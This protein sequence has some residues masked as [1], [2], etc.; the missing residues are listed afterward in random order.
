MTNQELLQT[1]RKQLGKESSPF[2]PGILAMCQELRHALTQHD[3]FVTETAPAAPQG[4]QVGR[5][6]RERDNP[7]SIYPP[8]TTALGHH[9][10]GR[11]VEGTHTQTDE[12][13]EALECS[14]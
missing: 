4:A 14:D 9:P 6:T 1:L 13:L 7:H 10:K 8:R 3:A 12:A 2:R 11:V 5:N